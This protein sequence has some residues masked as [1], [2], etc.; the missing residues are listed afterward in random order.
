MKIND[1][2]FISN[3]N[4]DIRAIGKIVRDYYFKD[5]AEISFKQFRNVK[6][7]YVGNNIPF[8]KFSVKNLSQQSIYQFYKDDLKFDFI[9]NLLTNDEK[10]E[11][12]KYVLV[13]DEINRGEIS[14]IFGELITLIEDTKRTDKENLQLILP[15]SGEP[16]S[17]PSNL[18]II[19]TMNTADRSIALLDV[20]L[21]R[22][23]DF[24]PKY[25]D[26]S[27]IG[28]DGAQSEVGGIDLKAFLDSINER[29]EVLLDKDHTIGHS[30]LMGINSYEDFLYKFKNRIL[31]LLQEYFYNDYE[32]IAKVLNQADIDNDEWKDIDS[33]IILKLSSIDDLPKY[34]INEKY[35]QKAFLKACE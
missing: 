28:A 23:F 15:Y 2:V 29:I 13:I 5:D 3:G 20:A 26:S 34:S 7:L 35:P 9:N 4:T 11:I 24:I 10:T 27:V 31:P 21:R 19:G 12:K 32:K 16:F 8:N 30:Y 17:L 22:R 6:W 1:L 25:P 14:K 33:Q 18:Y